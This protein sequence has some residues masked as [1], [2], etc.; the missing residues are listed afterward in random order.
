MLLN[1][2]TKVYSNNVIDH[3][4]R[5]KIKKSAPLLSRLK[6]IMSFN[7]YIYIC[8]YIHLSRHYKFK[9]KK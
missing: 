1:K 6:L 5:I 3:Y 7:I 2:E 9:S 8:I 4:S